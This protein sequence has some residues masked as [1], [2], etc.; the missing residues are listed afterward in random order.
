MG[1]VMTP[2]CYLCCRGHLCTPI[3]VWDPDLL[4]GH[5][6]HFTNVRGALGV[7]YPSVPEGFCVILHIQSVYPLLY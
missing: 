3:S 6:N 1:E 4:L 2:A 7:I 5:F